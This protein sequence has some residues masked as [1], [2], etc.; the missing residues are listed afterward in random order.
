MIPS[1][2]DHSQAGQQLSSASL[3]RP[4]VDGAL[5]LLTMDD[6]RGN[7]SSK[8]SISSVNINDSSSSSSNPRSLLFPTPPMLP[9]TSQSTQSSPK[10]PSDGRLF[11][12]RSKHMT[13]EQQTR[14]NRSRV[15]DSLP[16]IGSER[17]V[18]KASAYI[19]PIRLLLQLCVTLPFL[20]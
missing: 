14:Q 8:I 16:T 10:N 15:N 1:Q 12:S 4:E 13:L 7:I 17:S 9:S 6:R 18:C 19:T 5:S 20:L 3:A 2:E 11:S